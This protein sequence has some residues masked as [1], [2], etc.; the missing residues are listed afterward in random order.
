M[1][2]NN[3]KKIDEAW[4]EKIKKEGADKEDVK[5]TYPAPDFKFFLSSL[6]M[7]AWIGLGVIPNPA[8]EK[9]EENHE[10]AKFIIDTLDILKEK[11]KGN[12]DK[13]ENELLEQILY[14]LHLHYVNK[15]SN[16]NA[17]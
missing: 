17:A 4:K 6:A 1:E 3:Q 7:Q 12:L 16:N 15:S 2:E 5:K 13:D 14:E 11:T 10:Q 8:T 9:T